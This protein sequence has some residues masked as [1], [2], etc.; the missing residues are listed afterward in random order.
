MGAIRVMYKG[1]IHSGASGSIGFR[2]QRAIVGQGIVICKVKSDVLSVIVQPSH[3]KGTGIGVIHGVQ[4]VFIRSNRYVSQRVDIAVFLPFP[5]DARSL[6][7]EKVYRVL[8]FKAGVK[9][10]DQRVVLPGLPKIHTVDAGETQVF[11]EQFRLMIGKAKLPMELCSF[12][13]QFDP[14]TERNFIAFF[15]ISQLVIRHMDTDFLPV[16]FLGD[17]GL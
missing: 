17:V 16:F 11:Y 6:L 4:P 10:I 12:P 9:G 15:S 3:G 2:P 5:V 13:R 1:K 8:D 7:A 14:I